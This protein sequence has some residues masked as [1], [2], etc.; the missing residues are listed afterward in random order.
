MGGDVEML[1]YVFITSTDPVTI[2]F[3]SKDCRLWGRRSKTLT[4]TGRRKRLRGTGRSMQ[5]LV[6]VE[7]RPSFH[8]SRRR[9]LWVFVLLALLRFALCVMVWRCVVCVVCGVWCVVLMWYVL[10]TCVPW[11]QGQFC[12]CVYDG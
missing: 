4:A 5:M 8:G 11:M 12:M 6:P 10:C 9:S 3:V 1:I 2:E 7:W